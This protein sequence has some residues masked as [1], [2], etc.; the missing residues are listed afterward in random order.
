MW[1]LNK[2]IDVLFF[3]DMLFNFNTGYFNFKVGLWVIGRRKIVSNYLRSWFLIDF[4]SIIPFDV[5]GNILM[6]GGGNS[7]NFMLI[8]LIR[9][10]AA[11]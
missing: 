5:V 2:S 11:S 10:K 4:V 3:F 7:K 9:V 1:V 6:P 8:R